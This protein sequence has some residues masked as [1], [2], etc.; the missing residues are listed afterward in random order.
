MAQY[1]VKTIAIAVKNNRIAEY[2]ETV[3]DNELTVNP[4]ALIDAG[5]IELIE[6]VVE[7]VVETAE[8]E[9]DA[10]VLETETET[11][12]VDEVVETKEV[13]EEVVDAP[14]TAKK[15]EVLNTLKKK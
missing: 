3:D 15:D 11:E 14:A 5:S 6:E 12:T 1:R 8:L 13:V 4:Q 9:V 10:E 2:G 7:E